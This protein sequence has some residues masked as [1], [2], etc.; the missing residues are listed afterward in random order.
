MVNIQ[1]EETAGALPKIVENSVAESAAATRIV[2]NCAQKRL[3]RRAARFAEN[4]IGE[5]VRM[6]TV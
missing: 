4:R 1:A 3:N 5:A 6:T 2:I